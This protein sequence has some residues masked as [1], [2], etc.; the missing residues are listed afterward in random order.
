M[1]TFHC[2]GFSR[3]YPAMRE[4]EAARAFTAEMRRENRVLYDNLRWQRGASRTLTI[5]KNG[6]RLIFDVVGLNMDGSQI[7]YRLPR[8]KSEEDD[9]TFE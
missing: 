5:I 8:H 4:H 1:Y 9:S 6:D 3:S 7:A 2:S